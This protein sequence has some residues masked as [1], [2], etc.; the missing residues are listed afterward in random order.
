MKKTAEVLKAEKIVEQAKAMCALRGVL[1]TAI[2]CRGQSKG[3]TAFSLRCR[4][5][6]YPFAYFAFSEAPKRNGDPLSLRHP[7]GNHIFT[8]HA[9]MLCYWGRFP[10]KQKPHRDCQMPT[11]S[12]PERL[13]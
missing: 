8:K 3:N 7:E 2:A 6:T 12:S 10:P 1:Q 13:P 4:G 11:V 5:R 9:E